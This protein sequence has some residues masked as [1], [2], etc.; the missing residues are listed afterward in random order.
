MLKKKNTK[1]REKLF[2]AL[3]DNKDTIYLMYDPKEEKVIYTTKNVK[4]VLGLEIERNFIYTSI[5]K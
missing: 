4:D 5:N 1:N 3:V 2:H